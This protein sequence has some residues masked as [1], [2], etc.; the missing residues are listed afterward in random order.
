MFQNPSHNLIIPMTNDILIKVDWP[1][2]KGC[3]YLFK[4]KFKGVTDVMQEGV[5]V[6]K[7]FKSKEGYLSYTSIKGG[8]FE[9]HRDSEDSNM[10][11]PKF[12]D[13]EWY[14]I[15]EGL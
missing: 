1:T 5:N 13:G 2:K 9:Y 12:F 7:L 11:G 10:I 3:L 8:G 4:G 14:E 6:I 15:N